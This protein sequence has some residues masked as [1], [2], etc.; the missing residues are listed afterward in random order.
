MHK[1]GV[2]GVTTINKCPM[3]I[4]KKGIKFKR[5]LVSACGVGF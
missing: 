3:N 1:N 2:Y 5:P 4:S